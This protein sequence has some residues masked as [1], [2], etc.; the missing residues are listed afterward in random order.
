MRNGHY[1]LLL[2]KTIIPWN[3]KSQMGKNIMKNPLVASKCHKIMTETHGYNR[4]N[5]Y[6]L[7]III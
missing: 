4:F 7:I 5:Y 1:F 3:R 6:Y 2:K